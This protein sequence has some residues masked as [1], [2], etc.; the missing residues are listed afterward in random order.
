[1]PNKSKSFAFLVLCC[2]QEDYIIEH[3]ESIKFLSLKYG[4]NIDIDIIINDDFSN[5]SSPELIKTWLYKNRKVFRNTKTI[6]NTKR[7]G[8]CKSVLNLL[9]NLKAQ[10]CKLTAADDVYSYE[11]IFKYS[12]LQHDIGMTS[13]LHIKLINGALTKDIF[14]IFSVYSS[15]FIY[16][17]SVSHKFKLASHVNAPNLIYNIKFLNTS[18]TKKLLSRF[19]LCEDW[20]IQ[21]SISERQ[22]TLKF[23]LI[24]KVFVYYRRTFNSVYIQ[25]KKRFLN[26]KIKIFK[27]L[28]NKE[29]NKFLKIILINR[30]FFLKF[31]NFYIIKYLLNISY[32]HYVFSSL[33]VLKSTFKKLFSLNIQM[34]K[35]I[36]HYEKIKVSSIEFKKLIKT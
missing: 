17:N 3:L 35:H 29:K 6:F 36:K 15:F 11:N 24:D 30:L 20:P 8:T 18:K 31:Y 13:G 19:E 23:K 10:A 9:N 12:F 21:I 14:E 25:F 32:Y 1:M 34:K 33:L 5:D 22:P 2:N 16:Q 27:Y 4:N 28:I 26:D 7:I